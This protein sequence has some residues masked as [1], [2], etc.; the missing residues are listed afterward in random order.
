[1]T[2]L[3]DPFLEGNELIE[4][5][6]ER[7]HQ[8][9]SEENLI[10][11]LN[12]ISQRMHADG[13][14]IHPV[15]VNEND[16]NY[17]FRVI[18]TKDGKYWNVA[19]TSQAE[20][21]KGEPTQVIS[22]FIDSSMKFC[23]DSETAGYIINPWGKHFMLSNEFMQMIFDADGGVEYTVPDDQITSE[24]LEDG[25]FLK[26]A[27]GICGRNRTQLNLIKL[28]RILRD[29]WIWIPCTAI[30]SDADYKQFSKA[31]TDAKNSGDL[32]LIVGQQF[33]SQDQ[34]RMV[35]DILQSGEAFF[36][37]VFTS[38]EEMGE[39]GERFSKI[40]KHF[41]EAANLA[42]NNERDVSGIVINPFSEA[43]VIPKEMFDV[44]AE[45][46]SSI[47]EQNDR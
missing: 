37:P 6:I 34:I 35:P 41:L 31:I 7:F 33:V 18:Q 30:M 22:N 25:S 32:N 38:A 27:V 39:Y 24:L 36:F 12:A 16:N 10:A 47:E 40:E 19:F 14:F 28:A 42:K 44:I 3:H 46:N 20:Y 23:L 15:E 1:M 13:H 43:F 2:E 26:R 5:A 45:M 21:E 17:I 11:I 4:E 9:N 29:S 8:N